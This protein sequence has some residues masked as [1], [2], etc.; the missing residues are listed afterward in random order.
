MVMKKDPLVEFIN[1]AT[2]DIMKIVTVTDLVSRSL[3]FVL[4][5]TMIAFATTLLELQAMLHSSL[6]SSPT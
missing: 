5:E 4:F 1:K 2:E 6:F 3:V